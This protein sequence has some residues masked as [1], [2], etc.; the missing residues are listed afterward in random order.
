[1]SKLFRQISSALSP[2]RSETEQV[3]ETEEEAF[4][5]MIKE[6]I[7]ACEVELEKHL[8]NWLSKSTCPPKPIYEQWIAAVHPDNVRHGSSQS[9]IAI[10][11]RLYLENGKQN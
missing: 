2:S 11:P 5:R 4:A 7:R 6:S 10:D 8:S 1:M 9:A 3:E